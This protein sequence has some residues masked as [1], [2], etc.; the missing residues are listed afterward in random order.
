MQTSTL[1]VQDPAKARV[2]FE[3]KIAFTTGPVELDRMLKSGDNHLTVVDVRAAED[4]AKG[5]I[6]G[7]INLPDGTWDRPNGLSKDKTNV[8]YCYTIVCHLA[9]KACVAFARQGFPVME[10]DGG[11]ETWK[12]YQL[13]IEQE[14]A[15]RLKQG[16]QQRR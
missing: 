16:N 3:N 7:A 13:D 12:E 14:P 11:F 1:Q 2:F 6:P 10:L 9:A 8:V 4:Y 15:N 5:H